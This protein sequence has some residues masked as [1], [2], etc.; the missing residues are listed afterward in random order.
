MTFEQAIDDLR[1]YIAIN[2]TM[3]RVV[4]QLREAHTAAL[5][6]KDADIHG[7]KDELDLRAYDDQDMGR[8]RPLTAGEREQIARDMAAGAYMRK[9][10]RG[11]DDGTSA[12]E[13]LSSYPR[14]DNYVNEWWMERYLPFVVGGEPVSEVD[15]E[16]AL[17]EAAIAEFRTYADKFSAAVR[18]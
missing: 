5:A 4:D 3:S 11:E 2:P 14:M 18:K 1:R 8:S 16:I 15:A 10:T 6:E 7:Y 12:A 9:L 13:F 17:I